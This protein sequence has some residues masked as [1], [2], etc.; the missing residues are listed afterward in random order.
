MVRILL[1][2]PGIELTAVTSRQQAGQRLDTVYGLGPGVTELT[3]ADTAATELAPLAD[4]FFLALPHGLA[5]EFALP[6]REAGRQVF[7]LSADFRLK[8]PALYQEFYGVAHPAPDLLAESVYGLP[9]LNRT[10]LATADLVACPGCYPTS[11]QLALAPALSLEWIDPQAIVINSLSGVSGAGRKADLALLF[12]ECAES[13]K[14]YSFPLHRHH[15][16]IEQELSRLAG[17]SLTVAFTPHLIPIVRG[18]LSTISAPWVGPDLSDAELAERAAEFYD[19]CP[20]IQVLPPPL[21]PE[22]RK[23]ARTNRCDLAFRRDRRTGRLLALSAIDNLGKGAAGQA[24]QAFNLRA[25]YPETF[26]LV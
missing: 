11:I 22:I 24:V 14:A 2:H 13:A 8:N 12:C 6:L 15:P 23:V 10:A 9:E 25:G 18:M 16:E 3:F 21:A 4:V 20:F 17:Q 1:R 7:D 26:G 19:G 5:P